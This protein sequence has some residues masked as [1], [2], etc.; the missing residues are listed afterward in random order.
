MSGYNDDKKRMISFYMP[1]SVVDRLDVLRDKHG[2]NKSELMR[3]GVEAEL[4]RA[5]KELNKKGGKQ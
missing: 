1:N 2:V 4:R 5:E 3:R